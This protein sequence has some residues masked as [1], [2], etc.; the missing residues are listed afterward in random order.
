MDVFIILIVVMVSWVGK[1]FKTYWIVQFNMC[2]VLYI[3]SNLKMLFKRKM[4]K[5]MLPFSRKMH[6]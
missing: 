1:F 5:I 3:N 4:L 6:K 2:H